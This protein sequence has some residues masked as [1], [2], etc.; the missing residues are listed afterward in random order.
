MNAVRFGNGLLAFVLEL[1]SVAALAWWGFVVGHGAL[2][3]VLLGFGAPAAFVLVWARWLAPRA[4]LRLDLPWLLLVKVALFGLTAVALAA[5]GHPRL[6][7]G[8]GGA[9]ALSLALATLV[10]RP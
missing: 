6:A 2:A 5:S 1:A 3:R 4:E 8:F 10:G 9:A 7:A